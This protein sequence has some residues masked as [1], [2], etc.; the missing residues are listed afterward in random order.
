MNFVSTK[1]SHERTTFQGT[2]Q[3]I[4]DFRSRDHVMNDLAVKLPL[5]IIISRGY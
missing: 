5:E 1:L 2:I 4:A 3:M